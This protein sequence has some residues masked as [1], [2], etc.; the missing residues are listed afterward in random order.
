MKSYCIVD[1]KNYDLR[2]W[3]YSQEEIIETAREL[4]AFLYGETKYAPENWEE[5]LRF[6]Q[7]H[8]MGVFDLDNQER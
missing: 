1:F 5:S 7:E 8:D 6:F 4:C 3:G 2:G